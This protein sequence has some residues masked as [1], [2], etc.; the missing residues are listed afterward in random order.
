MDINHTDKD[1]YPYQTILDLYESG[2]PSEV[3]AS[4]LDINIGDVTDTLRKI[5]SEDKRKDASVLH[6]SQAPKMGMPDLVNIF[7]TE[8]AIKDTQ[9]RI[10]EKLK[11][12][13]QFNIPLEST[14]QLLEKLA[15]SNIILVILHVDLVS[16]TKLSMNLPLKRLVPI[17]QSFTQEMS[18]VIEAYGGYVFK[19]MGDA[20]F[21][22]F[23]TEKNNQHLAC[24]NAVNCGYSMVKVIKKGMNSIL[25]EWGYPELDIRIGIDVGENAVVEYGAEANIQATGHGQKIPKE[26]KDGTIFPN[27]EDKINN[28]GRSIPITK[29]KPHL[30][31]LG[32]TINIASKMTSI[33]KPNQIIVGE[34][35]YNKLPIEK[36]NEF[37]KVHIDNNSWNYLD[38][39]TGSIYGLYCNW[40]KL[41]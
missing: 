35:V 12:K 14:Q 7:D 36:K 19:Y 24:A 13:S 34:A 40:I 39:S 32:Y 2:I 25:S 33:A 10:W 1:L 22:F 38:S 20:V 5:Q 9:K 26:E 31:I 3:I 30:D 16:S 17:I 21:A 29:K 41:S 11:V 15:S 37:E 6:A 18:L 28:P 4:Q 23:F 8:S 27:M